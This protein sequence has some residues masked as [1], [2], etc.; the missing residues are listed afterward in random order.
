MHGFSLLLIANDCDELLAEVDDRLASRLRAAKQIR[1]HSYISNE[2]VYILYERAKR[3]LIPEANTDAELETIA[4]GAGAD[5]RVAIATLRI[6][7]KQAKR[8]N[9]EQSRA[10][11]S[12][13][14]PPTHYRKSV[15]RTSNLLLVIKGKCTRGIE[16]SDT[17]RT[18]SAFLTD[19]ITSQIG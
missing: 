2:L 15:R 6:A 1:F 7:A 18:E 10:T 14:R 16:F 4:D 3:G 12:R 8:E 5:A 19:I 17:Y 11:T 9:A 13:P